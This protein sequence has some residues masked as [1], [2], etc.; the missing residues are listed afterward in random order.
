MARSA[1][2]AR[3]RR[4]GSLGPHT[5][6]IGDID[7]ARE[8]ASNDDLDQDDPEAGE[9][10]G[11]QTTLGDVVGEGTSDSDGSALD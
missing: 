11:V 9:A 6:P 5:P 10:A 2:A 4:T 8:R 1:P 3:A 7:L